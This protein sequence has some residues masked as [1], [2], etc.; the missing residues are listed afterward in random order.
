[1]NLKAAL[2]LIFLSIVISSTMHAQ[3]NSGNLTQYTE[4]DGLPGAQVN[5]LLVDRF[6]YIWTGTI[7]GLARFDGYQ[8]KR[9]YSNPNDTTSL[10][11]LIIW[12]LFEDYKGQ[13]WIGS[14]PA[15]LN[16][17]N[18]VLKKFKQYEFANL[19]DH[20]ANVELLVAAM[21]EDNNKRMYFGVNTYLNETIF[22]ALLYKDENDNKIKRFIA[23]DS[24]SI[25]NIISMVKDKAG[26][27][28]VLSYSGLFKID[29]AKNIT[30]ISIPIHELT[31]N[32]EYPSDIKIDNSGHVLIITTTSRLYDLNPGTGIYKTWISDKVIL[33]VRNDLMRTVIAL[34][35]LDNIWI[36][37]NAGIQYFNRKTCKFSV[38]NSGVK[39]ELEHILANHLIVDS[40]GT[41]WIG[42]SNNG[43][44]KYENKAQLNSYIYNK[45][46][47]NSITS[48]W[49]NFIYETSDGK[50]WIGTSGS[51]NTS[52]INILDTRT[53]ILTPIPF[54]R[55]S[56]QLDG[57]F[58]LWENTPGELYVG[59]FKKLFQLSE[60]TLALKPVSLHGAPDTITILYH[61]KDSRQNEWLCTLT[62]LFKKSK[63]AQLFT[64][65][66]LSKVDGSD[67]G[68]NQVTRAYE[69]KKHG[70]WLTTDNGLFLYNYNTDKIERHGFDKTKGD[71]FT[72]QDINSFYEDNNGIA[73]V[74]SWRGGLSKYNVETKKIFTYTINDGLPSMSIQGILPDEKNNSLWLSTFEGLSRFNLSTQ[75]F[76]NFSVADGIQGQL[77]ADGAFLKTSKGLFVFGGSNGITVF[78]ADEVEKS[79]VPPKVFLTEL[80]IFNRTVIPG[81]GHILEKP[82]YETQ[83]IIL[84]Y[85]SKNISIEFSVLHYSNPAKNK[86][87]YKL[88]NYDN[89]WRDA[90]SLHEAIYSN[91][92]SG[93][94]IFHVKAANDK[95]VWNQQGATLKIIIK[96][97]WWRTN[98]AYIIYGVIIICI[99]ILTIRYF[100]R[101][102]IKK[103]KEKNQARE[104]E[105][106]KEIEKAY[107]KLAETHEALK[108]T[109]AQLIH[110]EK[111]ASLGSLTAGIAHE[112]QNP[113][114]F[115]NNFSEVNTDLINELQTELQ[116]GSSAEALDISN[117]IKE[118]QEKIYHHGK[119]A[120]AI[121][122]GMLQHSRTSAGVKE[123]TNINSVCDEYLR[124]SYHGLKAKDKNFNAD[125][126]TSFDESI[127]QINV[128]G[129]DISR[130]M[131]NLFNNA[132]Y[133]VNE[134]RKN[135]GENYK[136]MVIVQ[137][138][139]LNHTVEIR[140]SDNG[141]GIPQNIV[142]KIFQPFFTTKPTGEGTGLGLSL[143]YDIIKAHGG[144]IQVETKEGEGS[145]FII[146]LPV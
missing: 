126:K 30:K 110:S 42:S 101:S 95:G 26:N 92:P 35:S 137:T 139:K 132:F 119:R 70:L 36:T 11:G 143:S 50:I 81:K 114:N 78:N 98:L 4:N 105:H 39:K 17:Y 104:L 32:N 12:S 29:T 2:L 135:A 8:F 19:V 142:D 23:P 127:G 62:G 65:Y 121:V 60:K 43:L 99:T 73:W 82:I 88:E 40:Y 136:P 124:L 33:P 15:F 16:V 79:S 134:K 51:S 31:K 74:G 116:S 125:F 18:P 25:Q 9:F 44:I 28:W 145:E 83:Q 129:Q 96:L 93:Q 140:V 97:P 107:Y 57:V 56:G 108:A 94:Y 75:Q 91:L 63:G 6:N 22:S 117:F 72:T 27:V 100:Q 54:S 113:L 52:G 106:A 130:V 13:I 138:K 90:G 20:P 10:Q 115:V 3:L 59:G 102:A 66:D 146:R 123:P 118:N 21:C 86:I 34:D 1:M 5:T 144:E 67:E 45:E 112:I 37:S 53:G 141:S 7:N 58:S 80:K 68:S 85:N 64:R 38:F 89:E 122:K 71:V 61:L 128:V 77:F 120:E 24:L 76:N 14:S 131:L 49:A 111:M 109:Q 84:P 103:E 47:K 133:A 55:F 41:L 46:V 48:G 87:S 69:S